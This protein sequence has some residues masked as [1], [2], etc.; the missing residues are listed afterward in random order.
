MTG[1]DDAGCRFDVIKTDVHTIPHEFCYRQLPP[2]T[3]VVMAIEY[4]VF[5]VPPQVEHI[6]GY[7]F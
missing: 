7:L 3:L 2:F 4:R 6:T 1:I 5:L